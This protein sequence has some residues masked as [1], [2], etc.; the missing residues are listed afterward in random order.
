MPRV[1]VLAVL[2]LGGLAGG[3]TAAARPGA[4]EPA[5]PTFMAVA[6]AAATEPTDPPPDTINEFM[7]EDHSLGDCLGMLPRPNCG[8][9]A[10]GGWA[11]YSIL[12]ALLLALSFIGWRIIHGIRSGRPSAE[13]R[14]TV[15]VPGDPSEPP[16]EGESPGER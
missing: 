11:Q 6:A 16:D 12:I 4:T 13:G 1:L 7:P 8:S 9:K 10:R 14:D 2:W 5:V 3:P 15:G